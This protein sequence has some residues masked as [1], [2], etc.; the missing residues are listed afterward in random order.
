MKQST[1]RTEVAPRGEHAAYLRKATEFAASARGALADKRFQ[2]AG[3]EAVHAVISACDALTIARLQL[4]S[5]GED[6]RDVLHLLD[7]IR[8]EGI[9][10]LK[11]QV[12]QVLS[13]KNLVE[14]AGS[15]LSVRRTEQLVVQAERVVSWVTRHV[16]A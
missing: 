14:Y 8:T 9:A 6:H 10:D 11:R 7:R 16:D 1:P 2:S 12:A 5:R 13:V 3:L 4:R 15:E